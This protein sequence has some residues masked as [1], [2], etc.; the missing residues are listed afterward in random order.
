MTNSPLIHSFLFL[1]LP[2]LAKSNPEQTKIS[3]KISSTTIK[4]DTVQNKTKINKSMN[5]N[6]FL[7]EKCSPSSTFCCLL[8]NGG[9]HQP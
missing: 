8:S 2:N 1:H 3:R 5:E 9:G 4:V 7:F 6:E